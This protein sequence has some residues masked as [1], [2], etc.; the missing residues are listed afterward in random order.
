MRT[1]ILIFAICLSL[2]SCQ[3][4]TEET[5]EKEIPIISSQLKL[6]LDKLIK[7]SDSMSETP[8]FEK[9]FKSIWVVFYDFKDSGKCIGIESHYTYYDE[10]ECDGFFNYNGKIISVYGL[11]NEYSRKFIDINRNLNST[12]KIPELKNYTENGEMIGGIFDELYAVEANGK[13]K[14]CAKA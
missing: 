6:E 10:K 2:L 3:K 8:N 11:E 1:H 7:Y 12:K 5:N 13:L 4:K 9:K 14:R